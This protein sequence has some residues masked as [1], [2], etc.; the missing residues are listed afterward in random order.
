MLNLAIRDINCPKI[1][2]K[3]RMISPEAPFPRLHA[4]LRGVQREGAAFLTVPQPR[5]SP[6]YLFNLE[7]SAPYY[8]NQPLRKGAPQG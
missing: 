4:A 7:I 8:F 2:L 1:R 3:S 6:P 5:I